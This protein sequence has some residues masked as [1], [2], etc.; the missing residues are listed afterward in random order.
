MLVAVLSAVVV[1]SFL[2]DLERL[3]FFPCGL[4]PP[5]I[6]ASVVDCSLDEEPPRGTLFSS[7]DDEA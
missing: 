6:S 3:F 1:S 7:R 4:D 2:S 5:R